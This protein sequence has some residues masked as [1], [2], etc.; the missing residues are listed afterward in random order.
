VHV[1]F[2]SECRHDNRLRSRQERTAQ[3]ICLCRDLRFNWTSAPNRAC[4]S[5]YGSVADASHAHGAAPLSPTPRR[6]VVG[7]V[8]LATRFHCG[9][10]RGQV[11]FVI[12]AK[13]P[14]PSSRQISS[15]LQHHICHVEGHRGLYSPTEPKEWRPSE[16]DRIGPPDKLWRTVAGRGSHFLGGACQYRLI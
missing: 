8:I 11:K 16:I 4:I 5:R 15:I 10:A 3:G 13:P 6:R 9:I 1:G 7:D 12:V 14:R 2:A